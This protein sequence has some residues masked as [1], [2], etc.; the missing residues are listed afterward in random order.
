MS[1]SGGTARR[2]RPCP[3]DL[4]G[5]TRLAWGQQGDDGCR[6][7]GRLPAS[8]SCPRRPPAAPAEFRL[9]VSVDRPR[10]GRCRRRCGAGQRPTSGRRWRGPGGGFRAPG[11]VSLGITAR[12]STTDQGASSG[13]SVR[14]RPM[15]R[16]VHIWSAKPNWWCVEH[17]SAIRSRPHRPGRRTA[18][19]QSGSAPRR[20][21]RAP[22]ACIISQKRPPA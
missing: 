10:P 1:S 20:T 4:R 8:G 17:R 9:A 19:A 18:V 22:R 16:T 3:Q 2:P 15:Q 11:A 21:S 12:Y 5:G 7:A 13:P 14:N 6:G